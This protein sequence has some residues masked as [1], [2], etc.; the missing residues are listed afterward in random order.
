MTETTRSVLLKQAAIRLLA[1]VR[2]SRHTKSTTY[3]KRFGDRM[4]KNFEAEVTQMEDEVTAID[5]IVKAINDD[6][7][8]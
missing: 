3:R 4:P 1:E 2:Q 7:I 8:F 6:K 5:E